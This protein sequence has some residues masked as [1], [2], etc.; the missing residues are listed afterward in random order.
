MKDYVVPEPSVA[1]TPRPEWARPPSTQASLDEPLPVTQKPSKKPTRKTT[2]QATTTTTTEAVMVTDSTTKKPSRKPSRKP[3]KKPSRKPTTTTTTTTTTELIPADVPEEI[4]EE[5]AEEVPYEVAEEVPEEKPESS[6]NDGMPDCENAESGTFHAN[7]NDC[8]QF[9]VCNHDE[10]VTFSCESGLV[11]NEHK[12]VCDW[13]T[14][15]HRKTCKNNT[16]LKF[17]EDTTIVSATDEPTTLQVET[18]S[19]N[20]ADNEVEVGRNFNVRNN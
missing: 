9:F 2:T 15:K 8:S 10:V 19:S 3:S 16:F 1:T 4:P 17:A 6:D 7:P 18:E 12:Q 5:V 13:P 20:K 11:F 14:K